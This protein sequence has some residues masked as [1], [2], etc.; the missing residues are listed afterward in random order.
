MLNIYNNDLLIN[1]LDYEES[2]I[3][4]DF[5]EGEEDEDDMEPTMFGDEDE[6][7]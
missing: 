4:E 1:N 3:E 7:Y 6:G 5:E 2:E